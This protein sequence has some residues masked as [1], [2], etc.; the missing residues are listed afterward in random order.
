M[1]GGTQSVIMNCQEEISINYYLHAFSPANGLL[2][3]W[4]RKIIEL[5][6]FS[7][8]LEPFPLLMT[9]YG[10]GMAFGVRWIYVCKYLLNWCT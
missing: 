5:N 9:A 10:V 3:D 4:E 6:R 1:N 2:D 7:V 8:K